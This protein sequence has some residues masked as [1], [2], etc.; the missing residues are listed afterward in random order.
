MRGMLATPPPPACPACEGPTTA[1]AVADQA[2]GDPPFSG[3]KKFWFDC[4]ACVKSW[5]CCGICHRE[6]LVEGVL[7]GKPDV[8]NISCKGG[9]GWGVAWLAREATI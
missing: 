4:A 9:C 6:A 7:W 1:R 5:K 3:R 8:R 2:L